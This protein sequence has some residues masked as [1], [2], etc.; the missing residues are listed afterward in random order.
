MI[1][2]VHR[3]NTQ[4]DLI[5]ITVP[6]IAFQL[7]MWLYVLSAIVAILALHLIVLTLLLRRPKKSILGKH[8]LVTGGSE[9][10]GLAV[11]I[12]A[13]QLGADVTIV[14]RNLNK[15][16]NSHHSAESRLTRISLFDYIL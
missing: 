5:R 1:V 6:L 12:R 14:A 16:G 3:D 13:A 15:L 4:K 11:A 8:V 2:V 10:I 9:G 7:V